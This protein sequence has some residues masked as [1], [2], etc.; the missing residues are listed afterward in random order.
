MAPKEGS[1]EKLIEDGRLQKEPKS[2]AN[3][4][5]FDMLQALDFL[6]HNEIVHKDIKPALCP[7]TK[8]LPRMSKQF[9]TLSRGS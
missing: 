5:F 2:I 8:L 4:L 7:N 6:A 1:V 3:N 9:A